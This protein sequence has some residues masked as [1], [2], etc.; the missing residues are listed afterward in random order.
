MVLVAEDAA[1]VPSALVA[2]TVNEY[3]APGVRLGMEIGQAE[4]P[5]QLPVTPPV[6]VA[7]YCV[8]AVPPLLPGALNV[9]VAVAPLYEAEAPVGAPGGP[10]SH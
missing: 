8:M 3:E 6:P 1:L 5:A 10:A 9:I 4:G 2:V 7:V